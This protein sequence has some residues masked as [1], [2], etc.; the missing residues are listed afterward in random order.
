LVTWLAGL[1]KGREKAGVRIKK[2]EMSLRSSFP[3]V[4]ASVV[5]LPMTK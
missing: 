5:L 2:T 4:I 3:S 1:G